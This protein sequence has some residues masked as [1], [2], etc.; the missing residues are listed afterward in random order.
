MSASMGKGS[1]GSLLLVLDTHLGSMVATLEESLA[2]KMK[3][4][5]KKRL[6]HY[7]LVRGFVDTFSMVHDQPIMSVLQK[8][9]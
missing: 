8:R 2:K 4:K 7:I 6:R 5:R 9:A 3:A 1:F